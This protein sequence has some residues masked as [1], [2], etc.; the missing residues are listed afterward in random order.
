MVGVDS[1]ALAGNT[2]LGVGD[3]HPVDEWLQGVWGRKPKW[4]QIA[5]PKPQLPPPLELELSGHPVIA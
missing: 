2:G 5:L 1:W 3:G 4:A